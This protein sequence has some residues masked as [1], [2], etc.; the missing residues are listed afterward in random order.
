GGVNTLCWHQ[1]DPQGRGFYAEDVNEERIVE[2]M[3]PGG[4]YHDF[5]KEKLQK[6]ARFFKS[7]R[8]S[9]GQSI[10]VVFRPYHEH[11]GGWFW[12]GIGH[13]TTQEYVDLWQFTVQ[14]LRDSLNVHNL[15]YAYSPSTESKDTLQYLERYPGD[16]YVDILGLDHYF[17]HPVL[18]SEQTFFKERLQGVAQ[19]ALD[20]NKVAAVTE[21][22]QESLPTEDWFTR[23]LLDPIKM[24]SLAAFISYAAV[25]R[26]ANTTHHYAPYPGHAS[27]TDFIQFYEEP[28]TLFEND[29]PDLYI[30]TGPDSSPPEI[31]F[32]PQSPVIASATEFIIY[33]ETNERAYVRYSL[34]NQDFDNMPNSF[35]PGSSR[36][37][38]ATWTGIQGETTTYY[39]HMRDTVGNTTPTATEIIVTIDTLQQPI[40]W[41]DLEYPDENWTI[42]NTP[43]GYEDPN[44][45]TL[46]NQ[47][48][49]L[50]FRHQFSLDAIPEA[51]GLLVKC[52]DGAVVY[53]NGMEIGRVNMNEGQIIDHNTNATNNIASNRVVLLD[54]TALAALKIGSNIITVEVH[55]ANV[56]TANLSFDGQLFNSTQ[57]IIP[58]GSEWAYFDED[59]KPEDTTLGDI[60]TA[61]FNDQQ[62]MPGEFRL[63]PNTPNPFNPLTQIHYTLPKNS[64]IQLMIYDILGH[65][66]AILDKGYR[67]S[68]IHSVSF[69]ASH[70]PS[71][72]FIAEL[73]SN[74]QV[75]RQKMMLLK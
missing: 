3:L 9:E 26:N 60:M 20:R 55:A 65:Q 68:G 46:T 28:Y 17:A 32:I 74:S 11:D 54:Q 47:A 15:L 41:I 27:V 25:W 43:I 62:A 18:I 39:L 22:G 21:V 12:W 57:V 64:R 53:V 13:C 51:L 67:V 56:L 44:N 36:F 4:E 73:I 75:F 5:Y 72:I 49:T 48:Q 35:D 70:L 61:I 24:D 52:H 69:D 33:L 31:T 40:T 19:M 16:A 30:K 6:S 8:G 45:M 58:L 38:T 23:I 2:K 63:L 7:L 14:Y 71:G 37:H 50:Y 34:E 10:P 42:G 29:L 59:E 1:R 66:I